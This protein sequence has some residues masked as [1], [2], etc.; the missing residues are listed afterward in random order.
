M[1][2]PYS[3]AYNYYDTQQYRKAIEHFKTVL[4]IDP[5]H[6][7][8]AL[9]AALCCYFLKDDT[10]AITYYSQAI[11]LKPNISK[12]YFNRGLCYEN[13]GDITKAIDDYEKAV[14]LDANYEKAHN[15]LKQLKKK[16]RWF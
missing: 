13:V 9:Y 8:S 5:D 3:L 16:G 11:E 12:N 2:P 6:Y 14:I 15:R 10:Q 1:A 4:T 7:N